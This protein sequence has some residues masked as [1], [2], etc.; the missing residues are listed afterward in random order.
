MPKLEVNISDDI[1]WD[2]HIDITAMKAIGTLAS[3]QPNNKH[4]PKN[5]KNHCF[6]T[7]IRPILE[8]A[9]SAWSPHTPKHINNLNGSS[10]VQ[11]ASLMVVTKDTVASQRMGRPTGK[12]V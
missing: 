2:Y 8:Y 11:L 4:C 5:I 7:L 6:T 1:S 12:T 10:V 3:L 9:F